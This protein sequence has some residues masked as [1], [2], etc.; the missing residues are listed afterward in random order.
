MFFKQIQLFHLAEAKNDSFEDWTARLQS[1]VFQPCLPS[2]PVSMGWVPLIDEE[3]APLIQEMNGRRMICMQVEERILPAVVIRQAL[4]ERI[5][6]LEAAQDRKIRQKEKHS[7]KDE[8]VLTLLPRTFSKL[9]RVYAYLDLKHRWLVLGT[10]NKKRTEQFF[11]IFK[12]TI[13][14]NVRPF[15]LKKVSPIITQWINQ[16]NYPDSFSIEKKCVLQDAK[17]KTRIIRCQQ[18]D[19]FVNSIQEFIQDGCELKQVEISWRDRVSFVLSDDFTLRS[20]RF[21]DDIR[22][23]VKAMEPETQQQK[24]AADFFIMAET[25]A[26]LFSDLLSLFAK[27]VSVQEPA[28]IS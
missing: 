28:V 3:N 13:S 21:Q 16:K 4:N 24:F 19:L 7:L 18:Q 5:K 8:V 23:E 1:L 14:E 26:D 15:E 12:K 25:F 22:D 2:I 9:T 17:Q 10:T 6:Q 27:P 11:S 20:L